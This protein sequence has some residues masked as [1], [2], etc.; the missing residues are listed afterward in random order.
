LGEHG[1]DWRVKRKGWSDT[2]AALGQCAGT[3]GR[4]DGGL[5]RR[6]RAEEGRQPVDFRFAAALG[7]DVLRGQDQ[8]GE[9]SAGP[10]FQ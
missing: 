5:M 10:G 9:P 4:R 1:C 2:D 3:I 7:G 8:L 6:Q